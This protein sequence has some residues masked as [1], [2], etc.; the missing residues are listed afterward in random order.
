MSSYYN[1]IDPI[2]TTILEDSVPFINVDTDPMMMHNNSNNDEDNNNEEDVTTKVVM[3]KMENW[4]SSI[5]ESTTTTTAS[6]F[7]KHPQYHTTIMQ[8]CFVGIL[9]GS[10][11]LLLFGMIISSSSFNNDNEVNENEN[12]SNNNNYCQNDGTPEP[13]SHNSD[14]EYIGPRYSVVVENN[15]GRMIVDSLFHTAGNNVDD[16]ETSSSLLHNNNDVLNDSSSPSSSSSRD[17]DDGHLTAI[18]VH[19][20]YSPLDCQS[21]GSSIAALPN[22][23]SPSMLDEMT[24][25]EEG[26]H[27][28][29]GVANEL[30][31]LAHSTTKSM[32]PQ[33]NKSYDDNH[34]ILLDVFGP[35]KLDTESTTVSNDGGSIPEEYNKVPS[36]NNR[37]D[38]FDL[39][40]V[41]DDVNKN[42]N[43]AERSNTP[44]K[45]DETESR[46][47]FQLS[48]DYHNV[49][50]T[51]SAGVDSEIDVTSM[52]SETKLHTNYDDDAEAH[53][54]YE[55]EANEGKINLTSP[56]KIGRITTNSPHVLAF[57]PIVTTSYSPAAEVARCITRSCNERETIMEYGHELQQ[58]TSSKSEPGVEDERDIDMSEADILNDDEKQSS[59][60][61][62]SNPSV[63][64]SAITVR[65]HNSNC[66][67]KRSATEFQCSEDG[68]TTSSHLST[69]ITSV[70]TS[71]KRQRRK[72]TTI[73]ARVSTSP[74]FAP[75]LP[76]SDVGNKE[77][78]SSSKYILDSN[79]VLFGSND[80]VSSAGC[81]S[82]SLPLKPLTKELSVDDK[83]DRFPSPSS[84]VAAT[85]HE[86]A[87]P[88]RNKAY[89]H[90]IP[91]P[92][93][94]AGQSKRFGISS[95]RTSSSI[96]YPDQRFEHEPSDSL[97]SNQVDDYV[98]RKRTKQKTRKIESKL[99]AAM[100]RVIKDKKPSSTLTDLSLRVE[101]SAWQFSSD[102]IQINRRDF[103]NDTTSEK[104]Y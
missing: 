84:T 62:S 65:A 42:V 22:S 54:D 72:P 13:Y 44:V 28:Q 53:V 95:T 3:E 20:H 34:N 94:G 59:S 7:D 57:D 98:R 101:E 37:T 104:S 66:G 77:N 63:S 11:V 12:N 90:P 89:D 50:R 78:H 27:T 36:R 73:P 60:K 1:S 55:Y 40:A 68:T 31:H 83:A 99:R 56:P 8:A 64:S 58:Q 52:S 26:D 71:D 51:T 46:Q 14:G 4:S 15:D 74:T 24:D 10:I 17:D 47:Q 21:P 23:N 30:L 49:E 29:R 86:F 82:P 81:D 96:S 85:V 92:S 39:P 43:V 70:Q 25:Y 69:S 33:A 100:K 61:D 102:E 9:G 79:D 2:Y 45:V 18:K 6:S 35:S 88:W 5:S 19:L 38:S 76:E 91:I 103:A 75:A 48:F 16:D 32:L 41:E 97:V 67:V 80:N 87:D 93:G